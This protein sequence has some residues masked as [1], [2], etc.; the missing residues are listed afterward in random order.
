MAAISVVL[1]FSSHLSAQSAPP[2]LDLRVR[3]DFLAAA[4]DQQSESVQA[5]T[6][7]SPD[8]TKT[9][10]QAS[11]PSPPS[12]PSSGTP[13]SADESGGQQTKR[14]LGIVPNF[15]A[16]SANAHLPPLSR[17]QKFWLATQGT[18]DY[19]SFISVGLQAGVEQATNTYPEFHQ[20]AAGFGRYYWHTFADAG[21]QN[22]VAGAIFPS[23]LHQDP[24]YYTLYRGG[25]FHRAGY[26]VSRLWI[27]KNDAGARRF[28]F[29]EILGS[30]AATEISGRYYPSQ[31]RGGASET[32][33]RF[34]SVLLNDCASNVFQEFWPDIHQKFF[35]RR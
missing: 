5:P 30:A 26:A 22:Y 14:I 24:R 10:A 28:N 31:E 34:A 4:E 6:P 25:F 3:V 32:F 17:K 9:T 11:P 7:Q 13:Q 23:I 20:G 12:P 29:S 18:F 27:T 8:N 15:Q 35:H 19:S 21:V 16:V 1:F 2:A 33:G